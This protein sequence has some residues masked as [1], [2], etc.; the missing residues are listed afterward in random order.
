MSRSRSHWPVKFSVNA[1]AFGL[2]SSRSTCARKCRRLVQLSL[3]RE[4]EQLVVRHGTPQKI[5]KP[6]REREVIEPA[7]R[8]AEEEKLRRRHHRREPGPHR[9]L[10]RRAV[11]LTLRHQR[12]EGRE[13]LV[14]HRTA[15]CP[16]REC[17]D[18]P[19]RIGRQRRSAALRAT[20][21]RPGT[22]TGACFSPANSRS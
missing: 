4:R 2:C 7:R 13:F 20:S 16:A 8:L 11:R 22:F 21:F 15:K 9:L 6:A 14:A 18:D 10:E 17:C 12:A 19:P 3:F 5:R 1:A